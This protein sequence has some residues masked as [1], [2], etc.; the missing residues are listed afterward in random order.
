MYQL[1]IKCVCYIVVCAL[2]LSC[3]KKEETPA[4]PGGEEVYSDG[5]S[6]VSYVWP[7]ILDQWNPDSL[8]FHMKDS[9]T[10]TTLAPTCPNETFASE[11]WRRSRESHYAIVGFRW[12]QKNRCYETVAAEKGSLE[13]DKREHSESID[14]F[15]RRENLKKSNSG[16]DGFFPCD[17]PF[18]PDLK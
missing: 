12:N 6:R 17:W 3:T 9:S 7:V 2:L 1:S 11:R 14:D 10:K 8:V 16:C 4:G 18:P 13:A 15:V 5:Y